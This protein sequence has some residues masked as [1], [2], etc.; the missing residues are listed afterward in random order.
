MV[1]AALRDLQ[2]RKLRF[3]IAVGGTALVFAV[4]LLLAGVSACSGA[5]P[6]RCCVR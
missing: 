2:W 4:S 6:T 5:R 3:G 1:R